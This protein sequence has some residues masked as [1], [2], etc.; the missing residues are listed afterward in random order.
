[1]GL[2]VSMYGYDPARVL[3]LRT[4]TL[5]AIEALGTVRSSDP[6]A[7]NAVRIARLTRQNLEEGWMPLLGAITTSTA[8]SAWRS[9]GLDADEL[10]D[11]IGAIVATFDAVSTWV[12]TG[13][14]DELTD[15]E[16]VTRLATVTDEL[17]VGLERTGAVDAPLERFDRL[18]AEVVRRARVGGGEFAHLAWTQL[19]PTGTTALLDA[20]TRL[21]EVRDMGL[22]N[23]NER[24]RHAIRN[25]L[26]VLLAAMTTA[27]P[28]CTSV[29]AERVAASGLVLDLALSPS[30][31]FSPSALA[32]LAQ[33]AVLHITGDRTIGGQL[34]VIDLTPQTNRLLRQVAG[35][36][37]A[38][39]ELLRDRTVLR[40]IATSR[41]LDADVV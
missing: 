25:G 8:M 28:A 33:R 27:V 9:H 10:L 19:G 13:G 3:A 7:A 30:A 1:M 11:A 41:R 6:A 20:V 18:L 29:L 26:G 37:D 4:E 36:P 39:T 15:G 2:T 17:A 34:P 21:D 40:A 14:M 23:G 5:R 22:M 35:H 24:R 31:K 32:T 12:R 38:A 16:L